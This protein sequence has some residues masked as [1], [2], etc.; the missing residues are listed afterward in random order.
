MALHQPMY[1]QQNQVLEFRSRLHAASEE[2]V[3][4]TLLLLL[5]L[6]LDKLRGKALTISESEL[7]KL[8]GKAEAYQQVYKWFTEAM[9][10]IDNA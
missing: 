8:Q 2:P 10:K 4:K 5:E 9:E 7:K 6:E 3:A 1:T